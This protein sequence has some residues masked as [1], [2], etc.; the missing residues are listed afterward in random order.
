LVVESEDYKVIREKIEE[1]ED[2]N[3]KVSKSE[4]KRKLNQMISLSDVCIQVVDARDPFNFRS[5]ELESNVL[6]NKKKL[7][8][9]LNKVDLVSK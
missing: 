6:K 4:Y 8:I 3:K 9:L 2:L 5:R 7:I 1:I